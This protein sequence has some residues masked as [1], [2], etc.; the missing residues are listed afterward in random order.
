MHI[1]N[2]TPQDLLKYS[3]WFFP[4]DD[5]VTI[6]PLHDV[7]DLYTYPLIVTTK[8]KDKSNREFI[9][10]IHYSKTNEVNYVFP[11]MFLGNLAN[12][13]IYF[14]NGMFEPTDD[15]INKLLLNCSTPITYES[16]DIMGLLPLK[17]ILEGLY[18]LD[19]AKQI[20]VKNTL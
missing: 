9:G 14:W 11:F 10:Y 4:V 7:A 17:G 1:D 20:R 3:I 2:L 18:Y 12:E 19:K 6:E 5:D 13:E 8:Y 16:A 15:E